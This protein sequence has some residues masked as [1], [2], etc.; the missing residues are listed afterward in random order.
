LAQ[1]YFVVN[2][3]TSDGFLQMPLDAAERSE[4]LLIRLQYALVVPGFLYIGVIVAVV[5]WMLATRR[6]WAIR[7]IVIVIVSGFGFV[8]IL[9]FV[10]VAARVHVTAKEAWLLGGPA[11]FFVIALAIYSY[12]E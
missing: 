8:I 11:I 4:T 7:D 9:L 1:A 5:L 10:A 12:R 3:A 6:C 2:P